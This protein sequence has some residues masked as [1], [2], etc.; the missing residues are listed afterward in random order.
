MSRNRNVDLGSKME[1]RI[2]SATK[3]VA[4][5]CSVIIETKLHPPYLLAAH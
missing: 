1:R 4:A 5:V 3:K 2:A